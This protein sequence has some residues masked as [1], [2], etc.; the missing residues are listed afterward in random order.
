VL[1]LAVLLI[2]FFAFGELRRIFGGDK[3]RRLF[4]SSRELP[5]AS[6]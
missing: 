2:P 5:S 6:S 4:F 3:L 1:I